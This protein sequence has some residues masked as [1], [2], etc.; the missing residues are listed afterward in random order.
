[1]K[2]HTQTG[3]VKIEHETMYPG[4]GRSADRALGEIM[5]DI[6]TNESDHLSNIPLDDPDYDHELM[7]AVEHLS[8]TWTVYAGIHN[9]RPGQAPEMTA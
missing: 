1:M 7:A 2:R 8:G 4:Y 9:R 3:T 5:E 6:A